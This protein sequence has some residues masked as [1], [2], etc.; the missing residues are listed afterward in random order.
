MESKKAEYDSLSHQHI[1]L[2]KKFSKINIKNS[3]GLTDDLQQMQNK[4]NFV[5]KIIIIG[6]N[7]YLSVC[8]IIIKLNICQT[9]YLNRN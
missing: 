7:A 3:G 8:K 4:N 1:A 2:K 6:L 9:L 5:K